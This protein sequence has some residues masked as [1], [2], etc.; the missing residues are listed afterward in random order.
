MFGIAIKYGTMH[1]AKEGCQF[2]GTRTKGS[3]YGI[4]D[5][6]QQTEV[7]NKIQIWFKN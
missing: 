3:P 6:S 4:F 5:D 1:T 2:C 7:V